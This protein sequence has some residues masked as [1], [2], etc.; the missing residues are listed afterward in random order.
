MAQLPNG[1]FDPSQHQ[2]MR[3]FAPVPP[4]KYI[5]KA[6]SSELKDT[7][8][9][10]QMLVINFDIVAGQY[11]GKSFTSRLNLVNSNPT[12]VKIANEELATLSRACGLGA[13]ND[14]DQLNGIAIVATLKLEPGQGKYGPSNAA[15]GYSTAQGLTAPPENPE[16][17]AATLAILAG[18]PP[19]DEAP[20]QE[21]KAKTPPVA[22]AGFVPPPPATAAAPATPPPPATAPPAVANVPSTPTKEA[23][24]STPAASPPP[25]AAAGGAKPPW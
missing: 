15:T 7:S 25:A 5:A 11:T 12:A 23:A 14:S 8:T 9:G 4:G 17:D 3:D 18:G 13:V 2:D 21:V 20:A 22:P 24:P 6:T 10:G 19:G 1:E 16:P